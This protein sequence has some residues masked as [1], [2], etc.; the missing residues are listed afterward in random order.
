MNAEVTLG[1][2]TV[3]VYPQRIGYL[4][5]RIGPAVQAALSRGEGLSASDLM[6]AS[7]EAAYDLLVAL[8]PTLDK[9]LSLWQFCAYG[10][11]EAMAA[12]EYDEALDESPTLPEILDAFDV[13]LRVS[14]ITRLGE[15]LGKVVDP[16][17]LKARINL[18]IADLDTSPNS[19]SPSGESPSTTSGQPTP[20]S[21]ESTDSPSLEPPA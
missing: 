5:N 2:V 15:L 1:T 19:P 20:T 17:L 14:G 21:T 18:A 4:E 7:K 13:G 10:S 11:A 16:R 9:R 8:I 3:P 6:P 12:G